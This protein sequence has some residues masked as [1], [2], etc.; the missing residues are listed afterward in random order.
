M[1]SAL[2][3]SALISL[4]T[5]VSSH[6]IFQELWVNGLSQGHQ[7]GIRIPTYDG[8][9]TDLTSND[10]ICNGGINSYSQPISQTIIP[11][12]AGAEVTAEFYHTLAGTSP[13]DSSDPIDSSHKG[14]IIA[15]LAKVPSALQSDVT[16]LKWFKVYED[17]LGSDGVWAAD[18]LI[19]NKGK[20][21]FKMPIMLTFFYL[22][23]H[24]AGSYPGA[25]LYMEYALA[26]GTLVP[27]CACL[28]I[29]ANI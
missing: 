8:P 26:W 19:T 23:L 18:K 10:I 11:V 22:A 6:T 7:E 13:L 16:G 25:Q 24:G 15:Y 20:V 9:I 21:T 2:L 5:S 1:K 29:P 28:H 3:F 14:P 27:R 4:A 12:P 17:D